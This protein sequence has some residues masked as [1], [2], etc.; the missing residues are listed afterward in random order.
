MYTSALNLGTVPIFVSAKMGLSLLPQ[1]I[2]I[3]LR[4]WCSFLT[5]ENRPS[6][7]PWKNRLFDPKKCPRIIIES[8]PNSMPRQNFKP[9][10]APSMPRAENVLR[11]LIM[12][13]TIKAKL[14]VN[15]PTRARAVCRKRLYLAPGEHTGLTDYLSA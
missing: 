3:Y 12:S 8:R 5:K 9:A 7:L 2:P 4:P 10:K 15:T 13:S 14:L 1:A 11:A 6:P